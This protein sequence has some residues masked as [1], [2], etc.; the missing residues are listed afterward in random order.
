M[1]GVNYLKDGDL[2]DE[3]PLVGVKAW[4][5]EFLNWLLSGEK[6]VGKKDAE[7]EKERGGEREVPNNHSIFYDV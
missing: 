3:G 2:A 7:S 6:V 5:D 1:R 4:F